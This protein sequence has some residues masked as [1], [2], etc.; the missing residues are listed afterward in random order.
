MG[1]DFELNLFKTFLPSF[2]FFLSENCGE[3]RTGIS[4]GSYKKAWTRVDP[5]TQVTDNQKHFR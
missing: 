3:S 5:P 2:F 4:V 1:H